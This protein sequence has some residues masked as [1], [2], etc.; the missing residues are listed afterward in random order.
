MLNS[1]IS[2]IGAIVVRHL[3]LWRHSLNRLLD[4]FFFPLISLFI[5]GYVSIYITGKTN[6]PNLTIVYLGGFLFW[7]VIQR[8]QQ[9]ISNALLEDGWNRNLINIFASPINSW[10]LLIGLM[11]T[12]FIKLCFGFCIVS[13]VAFLLFHFNIL[14]F[15]LYLP[16]F[17]INVLLSGWWMGLFANGLIIRFGYEMEALSWTVIF[18]L[19]PFVG[20]FY[21]L[22]ILP[23]WMQN[24]AHILP[25]SYMF[26]GL[27]KFV[28]T[29]LF[30][31][32]MFGMSLALNI[33]Y[34]IIMLIFYKKMFDAARVKGYLVKLF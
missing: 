7:M 3:Y 13:L 17:V 2:R 29:G 18:I 21:P 31:W 15:G 28:F 22:S 27:R 9:D 25:P 5:W 26:E 24:I 4:S 19:Q 6:T 32:K 14:M 33:V 10:E 12:A 11:V 1:H 20:V 8:T 16:L 30:D 23:G 34:I